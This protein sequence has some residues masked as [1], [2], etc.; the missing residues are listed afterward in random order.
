M[1]KVTI[2]V[3][4]DGHE[5]SSEEAAERHERSLLRNFVNT[6][7]YRVS[8]SP[9]LTE[10]RV[11][12]QPVGLLAVNAKSHHEMFARHW[13]YEKYGNAVAF[14]MGVPGSNA[15]IPNWSITLVSTEK[16]IESELPVLDT[17]EDSALKLSS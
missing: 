9:D 1:K 6:K 4:A 13:C 2:W 11:G 3:T 7:F 14:V 5:F 12:P 15:I 10:G 8:A 16:A 17:V